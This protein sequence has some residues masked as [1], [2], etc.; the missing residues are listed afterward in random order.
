MNP[1]DEYEKPDVPDFGPSLS[2]Q[3]ITEEDKAQFQSLKTAALASFDR[4]EQAQLD[5][6]VA[7]A[8]VNQLIDLGEHVLALV[9][10]YAPMFMPVQGGNS[11]P[12]PTGISGKINQV[13]TAF[14]QARGVLTELS[15]L[16]S[17]LGIKIPGIV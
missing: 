5:A 1:N 9:E 3:K 12:Q 11:A 10:K 16:L 6:H 4:L 14:T 7:I 15:P 17:G 13:S 2:G 8:T